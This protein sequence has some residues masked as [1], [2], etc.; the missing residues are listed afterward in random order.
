MQSY[1]ETAQLDAPR[2]VLRSMLRGLACRCPHCGKG[3][4]FARFAASADTCAVCGEELHH[5]RADDMPAYLVIFVAGHLIVG[6]YLG[7]EMLVEWTAFQHMALW[8]PLTAIVC[9]G[10]LQPLKGAVI[11]LQWALRMHGFGAG[12]PDHGHD[13]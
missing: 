8:L 6:A 12:E 5:H 10:L 1:G 3:R 13:R 11:G 4:L 9:I 2:P 7:V